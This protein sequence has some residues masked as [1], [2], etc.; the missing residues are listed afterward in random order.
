MLDS[1]HKRK[2]SVV[3]IFIRNEV[4]LV[5]SLF[6]RRHIS[7]KFELVLNFHLL[8]K[9]VLVSLL[10]HFFIVLQIIFEL[11]VLFGLKFGLILVEQ[12]GVIELFQ[13][14]PLV[15]LHLQL[16]VIE[17]ASHFLLHFN[18][19][20]LL[21]IP[22]FDLVKIS[23]FFLFQQVQPSTLWTTHLVRIFVLH[24]TLEVLNHPLSFHLLAVVGTNTLQ[25]LIIIL[26]LIDMILAL[27]YGFFQCNRLFQLLVHHILLPHFSL[28]LSF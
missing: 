7:V 20:L 9:H 25:T 18:K 21:V 6:Y 4:V 8:V 3:K 5:E 10:L 15:Q 16:L 12:A 17:V 23:F 24:F 26:H 2:L 27:L 14:L 19:F 13:M 22:F 1:R 11:T 28:F